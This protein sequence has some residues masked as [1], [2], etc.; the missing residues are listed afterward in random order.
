[1]SPYVAI[2]A[3]LIAG[4]VAI[5]ALALGRPLAVEERSAPDGTRAVSIGLNQDSAQ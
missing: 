1:M 3:M 5:V 2:V 4:V